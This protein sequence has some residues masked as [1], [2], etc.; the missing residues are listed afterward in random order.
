MAAFSDLPPEILTII[1]QA[2]PS[3]AFS[4][5]CLV[6]KRL[7]EACLPFLFAS[8]RGSGKPE[9]TWRRFQLFLNRIMGDHTLGRHVK[10]VFIHEIDDDDTAALQ[11]LIGPLLSQAS[12][13]Q[14]F[15]I[16]GHPNL[17]PLL[18]KPLP[19]GDP[20]SSTCKTFAV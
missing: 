19:Q 16:P 1:F 14:Q 20:P 2:L 7:Y 4:S 3:S 9:Q 10:S 17:L 6:S 15:A 13:I 11:G 18:E 8:F 5:T 12:N